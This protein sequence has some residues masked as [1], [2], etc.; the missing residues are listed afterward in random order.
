MKVR[1][2]QTNEMFVIQ[3]TRVTSIHVKYTKFL[4]QLQKVSIETMIFSL[5][6]GKKITVSSSPKNYANF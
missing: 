4:K 2:R 5:C 1:L 3:S 6:V